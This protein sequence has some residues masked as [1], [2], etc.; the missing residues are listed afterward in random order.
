MEKLLG[1]HSAT[2]YAL[3]R[4]VSGVLFSIH[5]FQKMFGV[6]GRPEPVDLMS[7]FGLAAIIEVV[8]GLSIAIGLFASPWAFLASGQMAVAYFQQHAPRAFW[9]VQ[10]D[11]EPAVLFCF[12]FLYIAAR[13]AGKWSVDALRK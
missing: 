6:L 5:G 3:L 13:G 2:I 4:F 10:N 12:I 9:P 8:G 7:Q 11:G 1:P